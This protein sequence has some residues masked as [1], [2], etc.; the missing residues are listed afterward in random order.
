[1]RWILLAVIAAIGLAVAV[2]LACVAITMF[3]VN[4]S[5]DDKNGNEIKRLGGELRRL[6]DLEKRF[7]LLE[8]QLNNNSNIDKPEVS[9]IKPVAAFQISV[10]IDSAG[11]HFPASR[12]LDGNEKTYTATSQHTNPWWCAEMQDIYY[13][14]R[15][16]VTNKKDSRDSVLLR[17]NGLRVGVTN[18]RPQVGRILAFDAYTLCEE[19]PGYMGAVGIVNCPDGV[20][21]QYVVIQ[22]QVDK[23]YMTIAEVKIYGYKEKL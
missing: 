2:V 10:V 16:V 3:A 20:S 6:D 7:Q 15:V 11:N 23:K 4:K 14:K 13:I 1:M 12:A 21:G 19:K 9:E 22:F 17:A 18:T 8:Q 5:N